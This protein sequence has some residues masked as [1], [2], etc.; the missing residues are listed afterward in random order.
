MKV[1]VTVLRIQYHPDFRG[2]E[3][4][5]S[6]LR[7]RGT[8]SICCA[9]LPR[10]ERGGTR[11]DRIFVNAR[12]GRP[13]LSFDA[14][15]AAGH[16]ARLLCMVPRQ[17]DSAHIA[18]R[19]ERIIGLLDGLPAAKTA[20]HQYLEPAEAAVQNHGLQGRKLPV[21]DSRKQLY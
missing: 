11:P 18:A 10:M 21:A 7:V 4:A 2:D 17:W 3:D 1:L 14:L 15:F 16:N 8:I 19:Q 5:L 6:F 9:L 20:G 13:L 12:Q